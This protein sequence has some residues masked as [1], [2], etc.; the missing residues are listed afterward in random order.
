MEEALLSIQLKEVPEK[1][2]RCELEPEAQRAW[3]KTRN[4]ALLQSLK[5]ASANAR[6]W[7]LGALGSALA[8]SDGEYDRTAVPRTLE[9]L[10]K[11]PGS[12]R[13]G[14]QQVV[15]TLDLPLPPQPHERLARG[16]ESLDTQGLRFSDGT[17]RC[18]SVWL[19][20]Q[21]TTPWSRLWR[22]PR[23]IGKIQMRE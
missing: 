6:R 14:R 7:L 20:A 21:L 22:R 9:A 12:V 19:P 1:V 2:P 10:I 15:V 4:R 3:L 18:S 17:G 13:F 5:Y 23:A 11:A 8:P 16:L